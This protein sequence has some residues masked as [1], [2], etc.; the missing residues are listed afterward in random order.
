MHI[1]AKPAKI[2][3]KLLDKPTAAMQIHYRSTGT[4]IV[5]CTQASVCF[6]Q[7]LKNIS[8]LGFCYPNHS[9]ASVCNSSG[10][11]LCSMKLS[12]D[13]RLARLQSFTSGGVSC[14]DFLR[15]EKSGL[16]SLSNLLLRIIERPVKSDVFLIVHCCKRASLQVG[17]KSA[18]VLNRNLGR[19]G[20]SCHFAILCSP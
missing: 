20:H 6:Q 14:K 13:P 9:Y 3:L 10:V 17:A 18:V 5:A 8:K 16:I 19:R 11:L 2:V 1:W 12:S 7:M 4:A 15:L